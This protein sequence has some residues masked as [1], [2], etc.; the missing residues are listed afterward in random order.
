M[1]ATSRKGGVAPQSDSA[2][3]SKAPRGPRAFRGG[4]VPTEALEDSKPSSPPEV[5]P[6]PDEKQPSLRVQQMPRP[7]TPPSPPP[8]PSYAGWTSLGLSFDPQDPSRQWVV[9]AHPTTGEVVEVPV[10]KAAEEGAT[11][12]STTDSLPPEAGLQ[13]A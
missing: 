1:P 5:L 2:K 8:T 4:M 9:L 6:N 3:V 10:G 13:E 7:G 12:T 11:P